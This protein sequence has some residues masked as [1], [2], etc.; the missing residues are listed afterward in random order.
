MREVKPPVGEGFDLERNRPTSTKLG[1]I[2]NT[3][4][5]PVE[6]A[7]VLQSGAGVLEFQAT[8]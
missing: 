8:E 5:P 3:S 7:Q 6:C 4:L 2:M 1:S